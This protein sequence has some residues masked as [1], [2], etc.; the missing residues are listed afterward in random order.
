MGWEWPWG[1]GKVVWVK[2]AWVKDWAEPWA[3]EMLAWGL[4]LAKDVMGPLGRGWGRP[5]GLGRG[6]ARAVAR[7]KGWE[8][9]VGT[10][11]GG[12]PVKA[13]G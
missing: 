11:W 6:W 5:L 3:M 8:R 10:G 4:G 7:V 1:M 2:V 12:V 9:A 13:M